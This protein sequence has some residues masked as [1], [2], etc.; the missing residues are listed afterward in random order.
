MTTAMFEKLEA[1]IIAFLITLGV[2][3]VIGVGIFVW[4]HHV[5][6]VAQSA[7]DDKK[8][9]T[10]M[11]QNAT[12][13]TANKANAATIAGLKQTN[14]TMAAEATANEA[15]LKK[16]V[17]DLTIQLAQAQAAYS[18]KQKALKGAVKHDKTTSQWANTPVPPALLDIL[19]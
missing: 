10:C 18:K 9:K 2:L 3:V 11:D 14:A 19:R 1:K 17:A 6:S 15:D 12:L 8:V 13:T 16:S 7:A 4:G 5:G